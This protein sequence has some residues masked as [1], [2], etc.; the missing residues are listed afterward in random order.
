[1]RVSK[2]WSSISMS[3]ETVA[4]KR[5]KVIAMEDDG[6]AWKAPIVPS[7]VSPMAA[8]A[9]FASINVSENY[10][11]FMMLFINLILC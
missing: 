3:I 1:M 8:A 11:T 6:C 2:M 10:S 4:S 7:V 9:K 5:K